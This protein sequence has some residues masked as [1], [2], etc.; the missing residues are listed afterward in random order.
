MRKTAVL[1]GL[2]V[3]LAAFGQPPQGPRPR[4]PGG[5]GLG[6]SAPG[7]G[8]GGG[9]RPV[10]GQPYSGVRTTTS[11]QTLA[12]GTVITH[13]QQI[14]IF[15]DGQGRVRNEV[16][17]MSPGAQGNTPP[18]NAPPGNSRITIEDPVAGV[19]H[20]LDTVNRVSRDMPVRVAPG[21]AQRNPG[22]GRGR[23]ARTNSQPA[24]PNLR[25][26]TLGPQFI[27]GVSAA[28]TRE[29]RT[30][31]A[32]TAGNSQV[33]QTVHERWYSSELQVPIREISSDPRTG[34]T[35]STL[36][37]IVR[38]EPDPSLFTV[39]GIRLSAE[40]RAAG[41]RAQAEAAG[42]GRRFTNPLAELGQGFYFFEPVIDDGAIGAP[43][44]KFPHA[45]FKRSRAAQKV[46][47]PLTVS[48]ARF[49]DR[50]IVAV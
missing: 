12:D 26:E 25:T 3:A 22:N 39:P 17:E 24:D 40:G 27:S 48:G 49:V 1:L 5:P 36:D 45:A 14:R 42:Q 4:G 30:I 41:V 13:Q 10:T 47:E 38:A 9:A 28:G 21:N 16:S 32:G 7:F 31:P 8:R 15:R 2:A 34:T 19:V 37:N 50:A 43:I 29:T 11:Q 33:I 20:T 35:S 44:G 23:G 18:G 46:R 6:R